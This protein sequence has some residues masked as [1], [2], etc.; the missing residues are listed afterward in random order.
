MS[1]SDMLGGQQPPCQEGFFYSQCIMK[2]DIIMKG[3]KGEYVTV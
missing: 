3:L 2:K 1:Q